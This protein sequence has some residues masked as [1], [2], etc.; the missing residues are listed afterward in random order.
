MALLFAEA[1]LDA[2]LK[3]AVRDTVLTPVE[4]NDQAAAKLRRFTHQ[5]LALP[6]GGI[7][8]KAR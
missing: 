4:T 7:D 2:T 3:T 1:G 8:A 5:H 6:D